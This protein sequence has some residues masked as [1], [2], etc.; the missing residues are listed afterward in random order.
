MPN[1]KPPPHLVTARSREEWWEKHFEENKGAL[2]RMKWYRIV[3]DEAQ[4]IKN[5]ESKTSEAAWRLR[6]KF[7]WALSGTPVQNSL[8]E[9][10]AYFS[11]PL[12]II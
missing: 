8:T 1:N 10:F 6:G 2:H 4:A 12:I 7:R 5:H 3:L 9:F 11:T